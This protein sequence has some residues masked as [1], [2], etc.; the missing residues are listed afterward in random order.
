MSLTQVLPA[1]SRA[2]LALTSR[3]FTEYFDLLVPGIMACVSRPH[4]PSANT[5]YPM[6]VT[7][8]QDVALDPFMGGHDDLKA[9]NHH[10]KRV[11]GR[12]GA[13]VILEEGW[14]GCVIEVMPLQW[15]DPPNPELGG[16]TRVQLAIN[17]DHP[18]PELRY[19]N[20]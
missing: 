12:L 16:V 6:R 3:E 5:L 4:P 8:L 1:D 17:F 14:L 11:L 15:F 19:R 18:N 13:Q 9:L 2:A 20:G 7:K 10:L